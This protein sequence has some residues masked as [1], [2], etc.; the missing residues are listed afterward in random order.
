MSRGNERRYK[1]YARNQQILRDSYKNVFQTKG[2]RT[3]PHSCIIWRVYRD[4]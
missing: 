3:E 1:R 2:T 4:I